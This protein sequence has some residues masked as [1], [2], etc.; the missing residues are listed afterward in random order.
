MLRFVEEVTAEGESKR[1]VYGVLTDFDLS[2]WR[3]DP[4][5]DF[6]RPSQP[7]I[8]TPPYM[9]QELLRDVC[10]THLY[11][12]DLESFFYMMLLA[13]GHYT[14]SAAGEGAHEG[15]E[16]RVVGREGR[17]PYQAWLDERNDLTLGTHKV[18]F[19]EDKEPLQLS[20]VFEDFRPWLEH[21]YSGFSEGFSAKHMS[22]RSTSMKKGPNRKKRWAGGLGSGAVQFDDETLGGCVDY[23]TTIEP[24]RSLKG[25]LEGLI[26]RYDPKTDAAQAGG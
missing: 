10:T 24:T 18:R 12:Y 23:S 5:N 26:I 15:A 21:L 17:H 4:K 7:V 13:C 19:F 9:A 25:E 22:R 11:R 6:T 1:K 14:L 3:N 8:G 16:R 20:P 2:F